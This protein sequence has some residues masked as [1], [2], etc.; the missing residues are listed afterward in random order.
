MF[1]Q[2]IYFFCYQNPVCKIISLAVKTE[3]VKGDNHFKEREAG[4]MTPRV[5]KRERQE[6]KK[7]QNIVHPQ[8]QNFF[9]LKCMTLHNLEQVIGNQRQFSNWLLLNKSLFVGDNGIWF[10]EHERDFGLL[11]LGGLEKL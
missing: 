11:C 10:I 1:W 2:V 7:S 9:H 8:L 4:K 6:K 3:R 5:K